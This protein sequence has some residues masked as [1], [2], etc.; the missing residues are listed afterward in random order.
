VG[1]DFRSGGG[2]AGCLNCHGNSLSL[3]K[4]L[5]G[6]GSTLKDIGP[7]FKKPYR[8][9]TMEAR[10]IHSSAEELPETNPR[11]PRHADCADCHNP[12]FIVPGN[13]LAGIKKK[14]GNLAA[15]ITHEYELCYKCHGDSANLP[16]LSTN[17]RVDFAL[18]NPSFHPVEGEGKNQQVVSLLKP[19][20][21]KK[22]SPTDVSVIACTTCHSSDNPDSPRGPHG[23]NYQFILNDN[24]SVKDSETES[25]YAYALCYRCHSRTSILSDESFRYHSIHIRGRGGTSLSASGTS[26]YTCHSSHGSPEYKY[27]IRFNKNVVTPNS[28]GLLKFVEKGVSAFHGECYLSCHGV[29]H[30]PKSY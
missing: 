8:H 28:K 25:T 17:K 11:A 9:P 30:N 27:L 18:T 26:C 12:H 6:P 14:T 2:S 22:V 1:F 15:E 21:E 16:G 24:F 10:G 13:R 5:V 4:A 3:P 7:E 20:K 29:D 19:Y 23:S